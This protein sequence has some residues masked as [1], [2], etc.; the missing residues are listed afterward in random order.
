MNKMLNFTECFD[1][2]CMFS[3]LSSFW[4][5]ILKSSISSRVP[6]QSPRKMDAQSAKHLKKNLKSVLTAKLVQWCSKNLRPFKIVADDGF[7]KLAQELINIGSK[8]GK[9]D[10]NE[11]LPNERTI[12]RGVNIEYEKMITE[13]IP[14]VRQAMTKG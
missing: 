8:Y 2:S 7:R 14:E 9:L 1:D 5:S 4:T 6:A 3:N 12:S 11:L 10:V 13:I